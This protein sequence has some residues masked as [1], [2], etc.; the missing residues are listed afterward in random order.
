MYD[1]ILLGDYVQFIPKKSIKIIKDQ[2]FA[3][4]GTK[5]PLVRIQSLRLKNP[6]KRKF[7]RIFC[8]SKSIEQL[9]PLSR[10]P[11]TCRSLQS[12]V[13]GRFSLLSAYSFCPFKDSFSQNFPPPPPWLAPEE[14]RCEP[15]PPLPELL[16]PELLSLAVRCT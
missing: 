1:S 12:K 5:R 13:N 3:P 4:F 10:Y 16:L 15:E 11:K 8:F 2:P 7:V 9:P 14:E 6:C